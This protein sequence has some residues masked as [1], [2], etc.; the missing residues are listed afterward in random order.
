MSSSD[1]E[2]NLLGIGSKRRV[3]GK[4]GI[5]WGKAPPPN[6]LSIHYSLLDS[7]V[8]A[9]EKDNEEGQEEAPWDADTLCLILLT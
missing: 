9:A 2:H 7:L 6:H 8:Q 1:Q 4:P 5:I 3:V